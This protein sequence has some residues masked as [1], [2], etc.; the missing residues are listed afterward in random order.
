M[1][2]DMQISSSS[3]P[4]KA[5]APHWL[6]PH[7]F[8]IDGCSVIAACPDCTKFV[9]CAMQSA[10]DRVKEGTAGGDPGVL[11]EIKAALQGTPQTEAEP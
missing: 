10:A 6:A 1:P 11:Q 3:F 8:A 9:L 5:V 4:G 2:R 7:F